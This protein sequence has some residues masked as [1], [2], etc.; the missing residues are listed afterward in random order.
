MKL[1][2]ISRC[3]I[4]LRVV[5]KIIQYPELAAAIPVRSNDID[6]HHAAAAAHLMMHK[7]SGTVRIRRSRHGQQLSLHAHHSNLGSG[8]GSAPM[9]RK[10]FTRTCSYERP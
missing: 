5:R 9:A 7:A 8:A 6:R 10:R 2:K 1:E 4:N 3:L